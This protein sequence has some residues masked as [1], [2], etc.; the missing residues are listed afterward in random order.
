MYSI[1]NQGAKREYSW[2]TRPMSN[3]EWR[4]EAPDLSVSYNCPSTYLEKEELAEFKSE[5]HGGGE[6]YAMSGGTLNHSL[7]SA[8]ANHAIRNALSKAGKNCR[9]FESNAKIY[10]KTFDKAFYP[11]VSVVCGEPKLY[12]VDATKSS[13]F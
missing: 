3:E 1:V 8:N 7:L 2:A 6:V 13:P 4:W 12:L 10:V 9:V 5:F 11:D